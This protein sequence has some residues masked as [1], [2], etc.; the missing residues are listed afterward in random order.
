MSD[1]QLEEI[2]EQTINGAI[3]TIPDHIKEIEQNKEALNIE[4]PNEFVYGLIMGMALGMAGAFVSAT[5]GM[6]SPE[7]Q[8][9]IRDLI[10]KKMPDIR[11]QI[12]K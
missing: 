10:Y 1:G 6:P 12:F 3:A 9:A 2:I 5:K 11:N 7:D 8:M 4:N